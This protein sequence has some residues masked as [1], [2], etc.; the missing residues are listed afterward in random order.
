MSIENLTLLVAAIINLIMSIL[1]FFRGIRHNK[2]N[3]Y[4]SLLTFFNFLWAISLL[5]GRTVETRLWY[6]GGAVLAYP[7]ALGIAVFLFYFSIYFPIKVVEIKKIY[8]Y[9]IIIFG[10]LISIITYSRLYIIGYN[11]NLLDT[12]Y[13]LYFNK[14]TYLLY[15]FYFVFLV[16]WALYN[17]IHKVRFLESLFKKQIIILFTTLLIAFVFGVYFDLILCYFGNFRFIWLGP[18]FT[19]F[20]NV[21]VFYLIFKSK[22]V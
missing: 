20:L 2:V 10:L 13:T 5:I 17:L 1:V 7:A 18:I 3:L 14:Y 19:A 16:L 22:G 6:E 11:K 4:F 21:Y 8:H 12:S 15:A 9:F